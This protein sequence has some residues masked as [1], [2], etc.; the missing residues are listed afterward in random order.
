[1]EVGG[2]ESYLVSYSIWVVVMAAAAAITLSFFLYLFFIKVKSDRLWELGAVKF[3][4]G[5]LGALTVLFFVMLIV[6]Y[7]SV[8]HYREL[9]KLR[10][11]EVRYT[12]GIPHY[13]TIPFSRKSPDGPQMVV[14]S[15]DGVFFSVYRWS[16]PCINNRL[17]PRRQP[18]V[19]LSDK[20]IYKA[21][22]VERKRGGPFKDLQGFDAC[23]IKLDIIQATESSNHLGHP[24]QSRT[25][26]AP[27]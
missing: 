22:Y 3:L 20:I 27:R 7:S 23:L 15:L 16:S 1:M 4:I 6:D 18:S 11:S 14:A 5:V 10:A 13:S 8:S 24:V 26:S 25:S 9:L 21:W 12:E 17:Q 2:Y 19:L